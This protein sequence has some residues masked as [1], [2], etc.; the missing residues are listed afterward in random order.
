[1]TTHRKLAAIFSADAAGYSR[2]MEDDET[3]TLR[4]LNESRAFFRNCIEAHDG[5][6]CLG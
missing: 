6:R 4:A 1:M 2:I 5:R 3:G